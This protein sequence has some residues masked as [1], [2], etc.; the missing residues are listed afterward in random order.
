MKTKILI[1]F[2]SL[3]L[4]WG[5]GRK[6]P[7]MKINPGKEGGIYEIANQGKEYTSYNP[8]QTYLLNPSTCISFADFESVQQEDSPY[9]GG[10]YRFIF[11]LNET[12]TLKFK[13]FT[14]R[15]LGK[16]VCLVVNNKVIVAPVIQEVIPSGL[17]SISMSD[18]QY[19]E[20][21]KEYFS[22]KE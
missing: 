11:K 16:Q 15:N 20:E 10:S 4:L 13:E 19:V 21:I 8:E 18:P 12:G 14:Q 22:K 7:L 3:L 1:V 2:T 17:L 9:E 5:C 6:Y